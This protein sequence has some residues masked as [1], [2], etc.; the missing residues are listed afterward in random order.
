MKIPVL[1]FS[2]G[3]LFCSF[4]FPCSVMSKSTD[5]ITRISYS[6]TTLKSQDQPASKKVKK[7]QEKSAKAQEDEEKAYE[8]AKAQDMKHRMDLQTPKTRERM[9]E[10]RK[11]A[12]KN[13]EHY[14]KSFWE[15]IFGH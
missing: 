3:C 4:C 12:D 11:L 2:T 1:I 13:N 7:A 10:N 5:L 15:K 9:K 14:H 6:E 8:R